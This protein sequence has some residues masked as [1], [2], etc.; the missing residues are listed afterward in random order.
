MKI[1]L[2][3]DGG[4]TFGTVLAA[5]TPNDGS[6]TLA[7][8]NVT[9]S[10]VRIKIEAVGNYFFDVNDASVRAEGDAGSRHDDHLGPG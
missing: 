5:S 7:M 6:E 4:A 8:P 3:T 1:S 2:S 9:A 10:D